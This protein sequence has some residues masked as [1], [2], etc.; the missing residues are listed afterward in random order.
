VIVTGLED[1][2]AFAPPPLQ[3]IA[4]KLCAVAADWLTEAEIDDPDC[5]WATS[6]PVVVSMIDRP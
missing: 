1:A 2:W 6:W 3:T 5:T 4:T